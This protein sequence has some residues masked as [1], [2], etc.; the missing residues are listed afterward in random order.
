MVAPEWPGT[1][2]AAQAASTQTVTLPAQ[3]D[4][5]VMNHGYTSSQVSS[6]NLRVGTYDGYHV[7][8]SF[9]RFTTSQLA[10]RRITSA[11]LR[12]YN[13]Q[14]LT[15]TGS[16][17]RVAPIRA[18]WSSSTLTWAN[19]PTVDNDRSVTSKAAYGYTGCSSAYVSFDVTS[20]VQRWA[21]GYPNYGLRLAADL[22]TSASGWRRYRSANYASG[23]VSVEP[24]LVVTYDT[25]RTSATQ[26][27]MTT[28]HTAAQT[29]ETITPPLRLLWRRQNALQPAAGSSQAQAPLVVGDRVYSMELQYQATVLSARRLADGVALWQRV[30]PLDGY[31]RGSI[32][33]AGGRLFAFHED[34]VI[35]LSPATGSIL[36]SS[37]AYY[38]TSGMGAATASVV[39][40][41]SQVFDAATGRQLFLVAIEDQWVLGGT[42]AGDAWYVRSYEHDRRYS[43]STGALVW[44]KPAAAGTSSWDP[45]VANGSYAI[46]TSYDING[47][48]LYVRRAADGVLVRTVSG[49]EPP[50]LVNDTAYVGDGRSISAINLLTGATLWSRTDLPE[51]LAMSPTV[52]NGYVYL[53]TGAW[54]SGPSHLYVVNADT[55]AVAWSTTASVTYCGV[56]GFFAYARYFPSIAVADR[57]VVVPMH[58]GIAVYGPA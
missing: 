9:L 11:R 50:A 56:S 54:D 14:S 55:G 18:S 39:V 20:T 45:V 31:G 38:G 27:Q 49:S 24:H 34:R 41:S 15:C 32:A 5:W 36:W 4:T 48:K 12:L 23:D 58:C 16:A 29:G 46:F 51:P 1:L 43:V 35:A 53:A 52:A 17:I 28:G 42:L 6:P 2:D 47:S 25:A 44:E 30:F 57:R 10:G 26:F 7:A 37:P 13:F 22:E 40:T 21:D 3:T 8:R 33:Y 19:Q